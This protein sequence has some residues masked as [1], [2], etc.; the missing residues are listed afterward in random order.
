MKKIFV[1]IVAGLIC[2]L[3]CQEKKEFRFVVMSDTHFGKTDAVEKVSRSLKCLLGKQP[4]A[5]AVFVVGDITDK[6]KKE[7]YEQAF[8]TFSD[9]KN[10][11]EGVKVYFIGGNN[12][13]NQ[14]E[15][16]K[17]ISDI[18]KQPMNQYVVINGYPFITVSEGG[19]PYN[20]P[21]SIEYNRVAKRFLEEK[22][23]YASKKFKGK[24]IFVF[25]HVPPENTCYGSLREE[26]WG[27][28]YFSETLNK[29]PQAVVFSGHS[30]YPIGDPRSINQNVFTSIN[31]GSTT[32][33]E[34]AKGE[35]SIGIHPEKHNDVTEAL[36]VNVSREG[37]LTIERWDTYRN[38]EIL[39]LWTVE[40]P[41]DGT[42]FK[43]KNR[44]GLPSPSFK[45]DDRVKASP[46]TSD[47][48]IVTF[49]QATDNENVFSYKIDIF[50]SGINDFSTTPVASWLLFSQ[51]Y[52]NSE[53]P[54]SLTA[55]LGG[56]KPKTEYKAVVTAFDS[57]K[58]ASKPIVSDPFT[59]PKQ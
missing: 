38:E 16:Y 14:N 48:C 50:L 2:C 6:G 32:Y 36:I 27:T 43:Y 40:A 46:V 41:Y 9:K 58:N 22:L 55:A 15:G 20:N 35:I 53:T 59:T 1:I 13:D 28:P 7:Q 24:P 25:M 57:W 3:S 39:P 18:L 17:I 45:A 56:L 37:N 5:E 10:V 49:P 26:G 8:A 12:H 42:N 31:D 47:S 33:G 44:D 51:F 30:H 11:P 29:Y 54:R 19:H 52:L 23:A 4:V 34:V 21:D